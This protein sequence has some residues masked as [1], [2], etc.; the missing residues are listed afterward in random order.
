MTSSD[1]A[2]CHQWSLSAWVIE[3]GSDGSNKG[4]LVVLWIYFGL[5]RLC[6]DRVI[7]VLGGASWGVG[8][9]STGW[10]SSSEGGAV[11]WCNCNGWAPRV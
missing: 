9:E 1:M 4:Y 8:M 10:V 3:D 11:T 5:K 6:M 2:L 7:M